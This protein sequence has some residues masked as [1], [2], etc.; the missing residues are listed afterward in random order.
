[1]KLSKVTI[2]ALKGSDADFKKKLSE[3]L[4]ISP[5]TLNRYILSNDD[6]LTKAS[7]MA[8]IREHIGL[9]DD[10][11]LEEESMGMEK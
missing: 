1:M 10:V 4:K 5:R 6:T 2:M 9:P 8:L 7:A 3:E 11:I